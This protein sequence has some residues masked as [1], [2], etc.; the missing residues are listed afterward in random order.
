MP[1]PQISVNIRLRIIQDS[2]LALPDVLLL[3]VVDLQTAFDS[4]KSQPSQNSLMK[5]RF[6]R[7]E[8][9]LPEYGRDRRH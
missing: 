2:P 8:K 5:I 6:D 4:D 9:A 3:L 7:V 1:V